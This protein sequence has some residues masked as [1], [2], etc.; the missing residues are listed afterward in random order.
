[1]WGI[2]HSHT[3]DFL[4]WE[5]W[6][7]KQKLCSVL[8]RK[9]KPH[10]LVSLSQTQQG[11]SQNEILNAVDYVILCDSLS[12]LPWEVFITNETISTMGVTWI[13]WA[14]KGEPQD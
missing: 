9:E 11:Q 8:V 5:I 13:D 1:M 6:R 12:N 4:M 14:G 7:K 2:L 10:N 3:W